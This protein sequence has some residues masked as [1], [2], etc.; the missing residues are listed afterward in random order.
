MCPATASLLL[1]R[2]FFE[3]ILASLDELALIIYSRSLW[4]SEIGVGVGPSPEYA[5][6]IEFEVWHSAGRGIY[7]EGI[8]G[9]SS[10]PLLTLNSHADLTS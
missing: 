4:T 7:G 5:A 6:V 1:L 3:G 8:E 9:S 10:V 2:L